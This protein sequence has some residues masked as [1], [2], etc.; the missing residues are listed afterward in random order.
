[1]HKDNLLEF[2]EK[3]K[4]KHGNYYSY[5][6]VNY[7]NDKTPVEIICPIHGVFFQVPKKH[8]LGKGCKNCR[9]KEWNEKRKMTS[10]Q[11]ILKALSIH[12][13]KYAFNDLDY[14]GYHKKIIVTCSIHGNFSIVA[15][16]FLAGCGCKLCGI[17]KRNQSLALSFEEFDT[18]AKSMHGDKYQYDCKDYF[19]TNIKL[20]MHCPI[21]GYFYQLPRDHIRGHGC[22][23][24]KESRGERQIRFILGKYQ[25]RFKSQ[26][27]FENCRNKL[28]LPFDFAIWIDDLINFTN[29]EIKNKEIFESIQ[30]NDNIKKNWC[31]DNDIFLL[32]IPYFQYK[33]IE[34]LLLEFLV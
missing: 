2:I 25:F 13:E 9:I 24:C 11:F 21:H 33:N 26:F 23:L 5:D 7:V 29:C 3:S 17:I 27:R 18:R 12:G 28:P 32:V 34:Q 19:S 15:K 14:I 30:L 20:K 4:V 6:K 31:L 1:M 22:P 8:K 10:S 16:D